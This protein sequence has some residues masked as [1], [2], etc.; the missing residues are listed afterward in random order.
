[1][2][3]NTE[4]TTDRVFEVSTPIYVVY[5]RP[6]FM[7]GE[8]LQIRSPFVTSKSLF[9]VCVSWN[10]VASSSGFAGIGIALSARIEAT[11]IDWIPI[12]GRLCTLR[13]E[14]PIEV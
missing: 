14:S 3:T 4:K 8:I 7:T 1:M 10:S 5:Q 11:L 2:R 6:V 12:N 13:L 9:H